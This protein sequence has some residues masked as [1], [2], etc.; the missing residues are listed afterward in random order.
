MITQDDQKHLAELK[1]KLDGPYGMQSYNSHD[2]RWLFEFIER[3]QVDRDS[4]IQLHKSLQQL[5]EIQNK[6]FER[7]RRLINANQIEVGNE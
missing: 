4:W 3:L 6:R 2:M 1:A 5:M 7:E